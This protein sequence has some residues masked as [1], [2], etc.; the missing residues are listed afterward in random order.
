MNNLTIDHDLEIPRE[1]IPQHR[2]FQFVMA[3]EVVIKN[4]VFQNNQNFV[5]LNFYNIPRAAYF[6]E[7]IQTYFTFDNITVLNNSAVF[8]EASSP[9]SS[10]F[11][12]YSPKKPVNILFNN[13]YFANN[14][15]CIFIINLFIL[16]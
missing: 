11:F 2:G 9:Y 6:N 15:N 14:I 1:Q 10:L 16:T 4:S 7:I 5:L 12:I 13:S 3:K 8:Y